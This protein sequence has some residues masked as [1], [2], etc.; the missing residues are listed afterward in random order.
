MLFRSDGGDAGGQE[1]I[2]LQ[3]VLAT[4]GVGARNVVECLLLQ[5]RHVGLPERTGNDQAIRLR[6]LELRRLRLIE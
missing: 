4:A 2:R 6:L 3:K 1:G 5:L